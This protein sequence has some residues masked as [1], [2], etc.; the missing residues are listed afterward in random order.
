MTLMLRSLASV[1]L[2]GLSA[3]AVS[4]QPPIVPAEQATPARVQVGPFEIRPTVIMRDIGWDSN[5]FNQSTDEQGDFTATMGAKVDASVRRSRVIGSYST[6]YEYLFFKESE[7]ERGSNRGTEGRVDVIFGRLRPYFLAGVINSHDRPN[8][9]IDRRARRQ[10]GQMGFGLIAAALSRT[11][12]TAGYRRQSIDY[13]EDEAFRGVKLADELNGQT[14]TFSYGADVEVTPLTTL[15]VHGEHLLERFTLSP[16]RDANSFA[17]G[18]SA[19]LNALALISGR[20]TIGFRAF[21]PLNAFEPDFTGLT[22]NVAV[23]YA[24]HDVSRL[25][26][27]LD[28]NLRHSFFE[29]TPY[30]VSTGARVAYT[31]RLTPVVDGRVLLS[32]ERI[33]YDPRLDAADPV[34]ERDHLRTFGVGAGFLL[35]EGARLGINFDHT[36][37]SSPAPDREFSRGRLYATVTYGF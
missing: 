16:D 11:T 28:R 36:T 4:A 9:E 35:G 32:L 29:D 34:K 15:S 3:T 12:V 13:A 27:G 26:V 10:Q 25:E 33:A 7:S 1:L 2:C 5:V 6:F 18:V 14:D 37:R 30:Y 19:T 24:F 23:A 31:Q 20:A 17:A 22:A 21:R 8:A